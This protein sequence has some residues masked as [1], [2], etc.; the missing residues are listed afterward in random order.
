M[1][2]RSLICGMLALWCLSLTGCGDSHESVMQDM[3]KMMD[4]VVTDMEGGMAPDKIEAKYASQQKA[5]KARADKLGEPSAAEAKRL[6]TKYK[7]E[8]EKLAPRMM[9]AMLKSGGKGMPNLKFDF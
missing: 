7:P 1:L 3:V 4:G 2:Q 9:Q 5:L 8:I 6:E